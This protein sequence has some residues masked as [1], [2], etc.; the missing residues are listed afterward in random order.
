MNTQDSERSTDQPIVTEEQPNHRLALEIFL[1]YEELEWL[2]KYF[3]RELDEKEDDCGV[4]A[5]KIVRVLRQSIDYKFE[6]TTI[7]PDM[8]FVTNLK[9]PGLDKVKAKLIRGMFV[10]FIE[11]QRGLPGLLEIVGGISSAGFGTGKFRLMNSEEKINLTQLKKYFPAAGEINSAQTQLLKDLLHPDVLGLFPNIRTGV[12]SI[13]TGC[14]LLPIYYA[15]MRMRE[16]NKLHDEESLRLTC[17]EIKNRFSPESERL[18]RFLSHNVFRV[19][20]EELFNHEATVYSVFQ[21]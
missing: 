12:Y 21:Y 17:E 20:F 9:A 10:T 8:N 4:Q 2:C 13:L 14:S 15:Y 7:G 11:H 19:L 6:E 18:K 3:Q 16:Q 1:S 5:L